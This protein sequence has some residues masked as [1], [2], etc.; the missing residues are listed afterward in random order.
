MKLMKFQMSGIT[1]AWE[2]ADRI[3]WIRQSTDLQTDIR[4]HDCD[5]L[6][7]ERR[8]S[9]SGLQHHCRDGNKSRKCAK[10]RL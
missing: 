9:R 1:Q 8:R 7:E 2:D 10:T 4:I 6:P 5:T 3:R